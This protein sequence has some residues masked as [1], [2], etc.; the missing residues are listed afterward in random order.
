[1]IISLFSQ[2]CPCFLTSQHYFIKH[3][4][5]FKGDENQRFIANAK[6]L[7]NFAFLIIEHKNEE[8]LNR[9]LQDEY[10][11]LVRATARRKKANA[12]EA[13][14]IVNLQILDENDN[15]PMFKKLDYYV[16][17]DNYVCYLNSMG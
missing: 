11:L 16:E 7:G 9:E 4:K 12:L 14:A 3:K 2:L 1:M 15:S 10:I 17:I 13:T 6:K 5:L 8:V